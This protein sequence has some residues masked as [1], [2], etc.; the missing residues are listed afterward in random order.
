MTRRPAI[1]MTTVIVIAAVVI[2]GRV[3]AQVGPDTHY[4]YVLID[5]GTFGGPQ[6]AFAYQTPMLNDRGMVVGGADTTGPELANPNPGLDY[7]PG[8]D[9][10]IQ[11]AFAWHHG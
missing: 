4:P 5:L 8:P 2:P 1:W 3:A 7:Y 10:Y 9:P 6:S 11:H